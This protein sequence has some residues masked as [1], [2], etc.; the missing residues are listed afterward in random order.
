MRL[1]RALFLRPLLRTQVPRTALLARLTVDYKPAYRRAVP[2]QLPG[3]AVQLSIA[4]SGLSYTCTMHLSEARVC[5]NCDEIHDQS[6]CPICASE[7]FA[8][9]TRWIQPGSP[10][11]RRAAA[12]VLERPEAKEKLETYRRL[13][14]GDAVRPKAGRLLRRGALVFA[15]VSLARWGWRR[16]RSRRKGKPGTTIK[17]DVSGKAGNSQDHRK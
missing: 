6:K 14:V 5:L 10:D 8:F 9:L 2:L 1:G 12:R 13:V 7:T 17:N 4:S 3:D 16:T 15:A 11:P